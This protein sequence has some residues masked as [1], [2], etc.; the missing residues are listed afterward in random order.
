MS[1]Y[2]LVNELQAL[3]KKLAD[4]IRLMAKYGKE[5]AEKERDFKVA[6][7]AEAMK[8]RD[9]G[10]S[11]SLIDKVLDGNVSQS[12]FDRDF[13]EVMYKTAQENINA[14]KLRIR[15]IDN[16]IGREWSESK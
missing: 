3:Q 12:K 9:S 10:M 16:Q 5:W 15:T 13:A 8:L 14:T 4:D 1:G 11:V 6:K 7:A 2:D